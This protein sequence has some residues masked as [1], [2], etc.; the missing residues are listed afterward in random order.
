MRILKFI[1]FLGF[2]FCFFIET[3]NGQSEKHSISIENY[4]NTVLLGK[5]T[6]NQFNSRLG[7]SYSKAFGKANE[8]KRKYWNIGMSTFAP[9]TLEFNNQDDI[10]NYILDR[11]GILQN[12][13]A[14][15]DKL[16]IDF[17]QHVVF[18]QTGLSFYV[19]PLKSDGVFPAQ[20]WPDKF[21]NWFRIKISTDLMYGLSTKLLTGEGSHWYSVKFKS[22]KDITHPLPYT[23]TPDAFGEINVKGHFSLIGNIGTELQGRINKN[24]DLYFGFKINTMLPFSTFKVDEAIATEFFELEEGFVEAIEKWYPMLNFSFGLTY[25]FE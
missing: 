15:T 23:V 10:Y 14:V 12:Y 20:K 22:T 18:F 17:E 1:C 16:Q 4:N 6:H 3:I 11:T 8:G 25:K 19:V 24:S 13:N 21:L 5:V 2:L 7:I 9:K